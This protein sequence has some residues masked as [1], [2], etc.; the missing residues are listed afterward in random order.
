MNN[1]I[2]QKI[3]NER[4][5]LL[6]HPVYAQIQS[7]EDL[8]RF[9]GL[10]VFAVWDFMSLLKAL[11]Q[12]LTCVETPWMPTA[13]R[14]TRALINEIVKEEE[15]DVDPSGKA[16]SHFEL[17]LE[18][19]HQA[20]ASTHLIQQFLE[21]VQRV[22]LDGALDFALVPEGVR[23]FLQYTFEVIRNGKTHEIAAAFTYGREDLIPDM[24]RQVVAGL[25]EAHA[26]KLDTF[27]YYLNRHIGLDEDHH[28][29]LAHQMITT[30]CGDDQR[31]WEE[32]AHTAQKSLE[33]RS[34]LWDAVLGKEAI[35][36]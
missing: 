24:F 36:L 2:E 9:M 25:H 28:G 23:S 16:I 22:G 18:A 1:F 19:M 8:H 7:L 35:E 13:D 14:E 31:K 10:H 30:L 29:P 4:A 26:E 32:A 27:I 3:A 21:R 33:M 15:S 34:L 20:G 5:S 11:Q 12:R 6:Q 17:Y